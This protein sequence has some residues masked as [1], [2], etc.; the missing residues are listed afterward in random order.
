MK[1]YNILYKGKY[2]NL[3][4]RDGWEYVTRNTEDVVVIF[5]VLDTGEV[6][7]IK[8]FRKPIQKYVI[9]LPAGLV[10]DNGKKGENI[11]KAAIRE[12]I[13][14]TG[15][16]PLTIFPL[17]VDL[18]SSP[19]LTDE[20]FTLLGAR[21]LK[22]IGPGGGDDTENIENI[23]IFPEELNKYKE[24]WEKEGFVVDPKIYIGLYFLISGEI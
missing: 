11:I 8:E 6:L 4:E 7:L 14:E 10:G 18:P 19:G 1:K 17:A 5:P 20:T 2:I 9:S 13:E 3:V 15:Y 16:E 21:N 22:K 12:M 23:I 24:D